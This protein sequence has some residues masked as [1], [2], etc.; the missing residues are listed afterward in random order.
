MAE[1]RDSP[2]YDVP[3]RLKGKGEGNHPRPKP[4]I[5][6]AAYK[7]NYQASITKPDGECGDC[8]TAQEAK[9]KLTLLSFLLTCDVQSSGER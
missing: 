9:M 4:H 8:R 5:D 2:I 7:S 1:Y 3:A 6:E